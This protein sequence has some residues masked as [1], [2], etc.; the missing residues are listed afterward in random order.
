MPPGETTVKIF[1]KKSRPMPFSFMQVSKNPISLE[2][3]EAYIHL[4]CFYYDRTSRFIT[5]ELL[6]R[7]LLFLP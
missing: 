7:L 2:K 6:T 5:T 3:D 4:F 1:N